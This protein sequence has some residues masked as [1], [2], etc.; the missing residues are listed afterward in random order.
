MDYAHYYYKHKSN[1]YLCCFIYTS[2]KTWSL[3]CLYV[4]GEQMAS[5]V[6]KM[7]AGLM[8]PVETGKRK[9]RNW[10]FVLNWNFTLRFYF[11]LAF[12][13]ILKDK[14]TK[15]HLPKGAVSNK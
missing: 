1:Y 3:L 8:L 12:L 15:Q 14:K 6:F 4:F 10:A 11:C 13:V 5:L 2:K 7:V 9:I